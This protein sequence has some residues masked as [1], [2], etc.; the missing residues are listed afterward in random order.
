[1]HVIH[2]TAPYGISGAMEQNRFELRPIC[3]YHF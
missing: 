2:R 3:R 1:V